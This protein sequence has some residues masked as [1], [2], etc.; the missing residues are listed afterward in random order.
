[1]PKTFC[2][3]CQKGTEKK[4]SEIVYPAGTLLL[5]GGASALGY[6]AAGAKGAFSFFIVLALPLWGLW[7]LVFWLLDVSDKTCGECNTKY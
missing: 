6:I 1:M 2:Q 3:N 4:K 5:W 7:A